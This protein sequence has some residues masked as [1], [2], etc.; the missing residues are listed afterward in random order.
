METSPIS[1]KMKE[2]VQP[3]NYL[4][5]SLEETDPDLFEIMKKENRRQRC[6][7]E[8]IASENFTSRAVMECLGSC[9][10][11]KYS[12]GKVNARYYGGNEYIDQMESMCQRRAL[13]AYKLSA[14]EWGVNVQPYSGSPANFAVY[15]GVLNPHDRIMGLDLPDGGHLTHGYMTDKKR[16]SASSIYFE[17]MPYKVNPTTGL[18]DYEKLLETAR[19]FKP[20][21]IIAGTSAYSRL[22]DYERFRKICDEVGA[23]LMADMAHIGGLVAAGVIPS[24]FE[25]C[26]IV[27]TTTHKSLR[28]ARSG[29]IFYRIGQKGTDKQGNPIMYDYADRIDMA[30]FPTLQGGPHNNNIAGVATTLKQ[31]MTEDFKQY[32]Q[33]VIK[34]AQYLAACLQE[35]GYKIVTGGTDTH[36]FLMDLRDLGVDGARV[37]IIMEAASISVNRNTVPGDK[38]AFRPGGIRV[39][40]PALTSRDF[41]EVDMEKVAEL[42]HDCIQLTIEVEKSNTTGKRWLLREFKCVIGE[43]EW[44][45]KVDA[46]RSRVEDWSQHFPMPGYPS[47][48]IEFN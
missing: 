6:G 40:T 36:L 16:I 45:K 34:N 26:D 1:K 27:T 30:V 12:E 48:H 11:N 24:P 2:D 39:G 8:M 38:S 13:E 31:A 32:S 15:T 3:G 41:K 35:K 29:L 23:I 22:I 18:I 47:G 4:V 25:Y 28:G 9:F 5:Q 33:Q 42:M 7:L 20:K 21:L 43:E 37:D 10:T 44:E 14:K 17:S 46:I 19:L